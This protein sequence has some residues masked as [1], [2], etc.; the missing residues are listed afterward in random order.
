MSQI[1]CIVCPPGIDYDYMFQRP[2]QL[3]RACAELGTKVFYLSPLRSIIP[4]PSDSLPLTP[5]NFYLL[6]QANVIDYLSEYTPVVY[7]SSP[8][9][10][11]DVYRLKP[12]LIVFDS[13]DEPTEEFGHWREDYER[14]VR[15]ADIVL[16]SSHALYRAACS[17]NPATYLVP[18]ACDYD[19]YQQKLPLPYDMQNISSPV[20]GY[21]GAIATWCDLELI[22]YLAET[23]P[24]YSLVMVGPL[25]NLKTIPHRSNL[26]WLGYKPYNQLPSYIT[27]FDL[28]II[29]FRVSSMTQAVNPI[30]M[31]EYLAAGIPVVS[32]NLP[33]TSGY[34][35]LV[36][37]AASSEQFADCIRQALA[38]N[39]TESRD[40]RRY[41]AKN[42]SW[43]MRARLVLSIIE[44]HLE[45]QG[46]SRGRPP[47]LPASLLQSLPTMLTSKA[48]RLTINE[49]SHGQ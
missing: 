38:I 42:N 6:R 35:D 15:S 2:Q 32:T 30:K 46:R 27:N 23:F 14:A 11:N 31:W 37:T 20:I 45:K 3:L 26:H 13:V 36:M 16:T 17:R 25:Y 9:S 39:N 7:F 49:V 34:D 10:L 41:L 47:V 4:S 12:S 1:G 18:N 40:R 8:G 28:G 22:L 5:E 48:I 44:E 29:P 19:F 21:S 24:E 33:E 43:E